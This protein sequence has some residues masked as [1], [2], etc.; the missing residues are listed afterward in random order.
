MMKVFLLAYTPQP[1]EVVALAAKNCYSNADIASL[2]DG[3]TKEAADSFIEM[4]RELGHE[5][6]VE[7]ASFTFGIEGVSRSLLAQI[8]RHRLASFSVKS[9]RYNNEKAF[10]Y[11]IP[12]EIEKIPEA[13]ELYLEAMEQDRQQYIKISNT[14][15]KNHKA[16]LIE[17]G[18]E[19]K[20]AKSAARKLAN[21]DARYILPNA[22]ETKIVMTMN[23]RS[24]YNFFRQRC[25]NR[26]QW[27]IR[28]LAIQM[29]ELCME[30]APSL[31]KRSGPGCLYGVCP[32]GKMSCGRSAEVRARLRKD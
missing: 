17:E 27:E 18:M 7:H 21:E 3:L 32:E 12:P 15:Y 24:L 28:E 14:L 23:T 6:P 13:K 20:A 10:E 29:R 4:L 16:R 9:Q 8:T 31:F 26:A 2:R 11:V 1:E 25:C 19:E 5:S 22:C 30:V